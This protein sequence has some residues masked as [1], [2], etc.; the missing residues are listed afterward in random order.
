VALPLSLI[1]LSNNISGFHPARTSYFL[2]IRTPLLSF[3]SIF[4]VSF[5]FSFLCFLDNY[6]AASP[7]FSL[8]YFLIHLDFCTS[9]THA[10][11]TDLFSFSSTFSRSLNTSGT[12]HS[13]NSFPILSFSQSLY[14]PMMLSSI[15]PQAQE[16]SLIAIDFS[17][18]TKPPSSSRSP[19]VQPCIPY[20][21]TSSIEK[22]SA[23]R[24]SISDCLG[25]F[26]CTNI[27]TH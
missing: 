2:S 26:L 17:L 6:R 21:C 16:C 25:F 7:G 20:L 3:S 9:W 15:S 10:S 24:L 1:T 22:E 11:C 8:S 5:N 13:M 14:S 18:F 12:H 4:L 19:F 23:R 27:H